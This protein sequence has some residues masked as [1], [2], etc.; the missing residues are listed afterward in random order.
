MLIVLE[1]VRFEFEVKKNTF[2]VTQSY[3]LKDRTV[4]AFN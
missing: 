1:K 4:C 3:F 2:I